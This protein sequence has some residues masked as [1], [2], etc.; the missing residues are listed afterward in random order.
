MILLL[1][2]SIGCATTREVMHRNNKNLFLLDFGMSTT[3]VLAVMGKPD[4][5]EK[6]ADTLHGHDYVFLY[7]FTEPSVRRRVYWDRSCLLASRI[8]RPH[9]GSFREASRARA[10]M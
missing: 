1:A 3:E 2:F 5:H 8:W 6:Y 7:Y 9:F 4:H 10:L